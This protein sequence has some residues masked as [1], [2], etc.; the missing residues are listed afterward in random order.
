MSILYC[1]RFVKN[2][3]GNFYLNIK[4]LVLLDQQ[5]MTQKT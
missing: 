5:S 1:H 4:L 3:L 2:A